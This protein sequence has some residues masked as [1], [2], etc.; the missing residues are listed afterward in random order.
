MNLDLIREK[1]AW[2]VVILMISIIQQACQPEIYAPH[3]VIETGII[4]EVGPTQ[5]TV[6]GEILEV[7]QDG[8]EQHGFV[9][10]ETRAPTIESENKNEL[11]V[12][13]GTGTFSSIIAGLSPNTIYHVRAYGTGADQIVYGMEKIFT[14][15]S[16][17]V[18]S[19][20]TI[21]AFFVD[22][23][24]AAAGGSIIS[25]GGTEITVRGVCWSTHS[26]PR[27]DD[28]CSIDG[29]GS[30]S[31][32]SDMNDLEPFTVYFFRAYATNSLGTGYGEKYGFKTLWDNS[33][34]SD[35]DGNEYTTVQIGERIWMTEN[36][37]TV[38]YS[39]GN[40]I[41]YVE[42][43]EEWMAL[44]TDARAYCY[45][46][47]G[48]MAFETYG[49]LYTWGAAM[50]GAESSSEVPSDVQGVCP[51]GW[52]L[53]SD[54]EWKELEMHLGMSELTAKDD[55]WRGWDE[56]GM[57]KQTGTSLWAEPNEMATN[58]SGFAALPGGFRDAD[59]TYGYVGSFTS[60]WS[61]TG[62]D[63]D[64]AWLRGLHAGRGEILRDVYPRK[65]GFSVRCIKDF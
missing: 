9:W 58:E 18:P 26:N 61:T 30:G 53:P 39:D 63:A 17:T 50:N 21:P 13:T 24:S 7:G 28:N 29:A 49:A 56:G 16:P 54:A 34:I 14:T 6:H 36:L 10:S 23:N 46:E 2:L 35:I 19:L 4:H 48:D 1:G 20:R 3:I 62:Y 11:G 44:G 65:N 42:T 60:F 33:V 8:I 25:N 27:I 40:P 12:A 59:G 41:P 47:N 55:G 64:G 51:S 38:R 15:S 43:M 45:Y 52:H 22:E 37:R 57:M 5:C 32:E 31:F